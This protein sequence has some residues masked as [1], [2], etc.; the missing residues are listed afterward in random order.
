MNA[1]RNGTIPVL[2][3]IAG[4]LFAAMV[5]GQSP[6][7][8]STIPDVTKICSDYG[9]AEVVFI[10]RVQA[11]VTYRISGEAEIAKARETLNWVKAEVARLRASLDLRT[12]LE[13]EAEF[14][15]RI[16]KAQDELERRRAMY[17]PPL[18][19][20]LI[21][22]LVEQAFRGVASST[23]MLRH[24]DPSIKLEPGELYLI[25]GHRQ[26]GMLE[27]LLIVFPERSDL[28]DLK[29]VDAAHI[30]NVAAAQRELRFLGSTM[31]GATILGNLRMHSY[32]D[33]L[34]TSVN[35]VRILVSSGTR[36]VEAMTSEDGSFVVSGAPSGRLE[37]NV[38]LPDDLT[39]VNQSALTFTIPEGGC[40]PLNLRVAPNGR[41]RGRIVTANGSSLEGVQLVLWGFDPFV[42][43]Y[44]PT[45]HQI[46][47]SHSPRVDTRPNDDG[48]FEFSGV[49]PGSYVLSAGVE[50]ITDGK[51]R[52]VTTYFPGTREVTSA[53]PIV[54]G[55][56]TLH[57]GFDFLVAT[58]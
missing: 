41:V 21:P 6:T 8:Q 55:K 51:R 16:I 53:Q 12:R 28:A 36:V 22:M 2:I 50:R 19:L 38:L 5:Y 34:G 23:V 1:K 45:G 30:A 31:T 35:G 9:E 49:F 25:S 39:I 17:P 42:G 10:G 24:V 4:G 3:S 46:H 20:T 11:P 7:E 47:G 18:D 48:T 58:E 44:T 33:G 14:E 13:R 27:G 43:F 29:L 40:H 56:A 57:D 54:V 15:I 26:T 32:G 37:T 52:Y